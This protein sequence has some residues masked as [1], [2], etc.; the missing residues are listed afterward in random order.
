[1]MLYLLILPI[2]KE[3]DTELLYSGEVGFGKQIFLTTRQIFDKMK[4][5]SIVESYK[6]GVELC[7]TC[8]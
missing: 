8:F 2:K 6:C 7:I 4:D 5:L 3:F 1:M